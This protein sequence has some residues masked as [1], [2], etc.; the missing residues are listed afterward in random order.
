MWTQWITVA[1][2]LLV[3]ALVVMV[4]FRRPTVGEIDRWIHVYACPADEVTRAVVGRY[5]TRTR[6][7]RF[8]FALAGFIGGQFSY[9]GDAFSWVNPWILLVAGYLVGSIV[10]EV[11]FGRAPRPSG[12]ITVALSPRTLTSYLPRSVIVALVAVPIVTVAVAIWQV[13]VAADVPPRFGNVDPDAVTAAA[14]VGLVLAI[15]I[16]AALTALVRRPQAAESAQAIATDDAFRSSSMHAIAG[17]AL[18][19]GFF[20]LATVLAQLNA[21]L[22]VTGSPLAFSASIASFLAL[23]GALASWLFVRYPS[24]WP[25]RRPLAAASSDALR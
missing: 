18:T 5:L 25:I 1:A 8:S 11:A 22:A 23:L 10:A 20:M 13:G 21:A 24:H 12:S 14:A 2:P 17:A 15:A 7:T 16:G 6:R 19:L 9:L 3:C 4:G